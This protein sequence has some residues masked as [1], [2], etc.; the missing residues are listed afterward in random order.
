MAIQLEVLQERLRDFA[1]SQELH[2]L[3]DHPINYGVQILLSDGINQAPVNL[4]TTG[5][6]V[7]GGKASPLRSRLQEWVIAHQ[8]ASPR[9]GRVTAVHIGVDEAGKGDVFGPLVIA[10]AV[11]LPE[12]SSL[13]QSLEVRD[14]KT[15][16]SGRIRELAE[17]LENHCPVEV[18]L[19]SPADY[20]SRYAELSNLN[21]LL[22]WGHAQV[23]QR[24]HVR[25]GVA[26]ALSDQFSEHP[27]IQQ[28]LTAANCPVVLE[29]QTHAE[30]DL[31]VAA[32]SILARAAFEHAFEELRRKTG[33]DLPYGASDPEIAKFLQKIYQRWGEEG[34]RRSAKLNFKPVKAILNSSS[35]QGGIEG[36]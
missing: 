5:R 13:L 6:M 31:A 12:Q 27:H 14:S 21:A 19:L 3:S 20:N 15:L 1:A 36:G 26:T 28:A 11:V 24:L 7:V 4:Y 16:T 18:F 17:K 29:E 30:S 35:Y 25:T 10:G 2:I 8:T 33:L 23:I 22:G 34:L 32:A 9:P